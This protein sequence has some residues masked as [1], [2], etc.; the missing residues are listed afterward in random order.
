M[1]NRV[2]STIEFVGACALFTLGLAGTAHAAALPEL[3][4][5]TAASGVALLVGGV[6]LL[7]ERHRRRC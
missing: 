7:L 5:S 6:L 2:F 3:D 1:K 4:P